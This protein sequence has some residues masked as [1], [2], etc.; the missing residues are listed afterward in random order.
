MIEVGVRRRRAHGKVRFMEEQEPRAPA[1]SQLASTNLTP[2]FTGDSVL[3]PFPSL[4][5]SAS[6]AEDA[7]WPAKSIEVVAPEISDGEDEQADVGDEDG[8][9]TPHEELISVGGDEREFEEFAQEQAVRSRL[10]SNAASLRAAATSS[11]KWSDVSGLSNS[12]HRSHTSSAHKLREIIRMRSRVGSLS[13]AKSGSAHDIVIPE[14]LMA[15]T[16][17]EDSTASTEEPEKMLIELQREIGRH[18]SQRDLV[19]ALGLPAPHAMATEP[20]LTQEQIALAIAPFSHEMLV[21]VIANLA[22]IELV[23]PPSVAA[24]A[25]AGATTSKAAS[26]V[27]SAGTRSVSP[28]PSECSICAR[29]ASSASRAIATPLPG[30]LNKIL[31]CLIK[32]Y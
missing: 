25:K 5:P 17:A 15:A 6:Q 11:D 28:S 9:P 30:I 32:N 27:V 23:V 14:G 24:L 16:E 7:H 4:V 26:R 1:V 31:N 2:E 18:Y 10:A 20:P 29:A 3:T 12:S 8:P 22:P 21:Q 19:E 13:G